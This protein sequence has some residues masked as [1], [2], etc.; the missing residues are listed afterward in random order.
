MARLDTN[1]GWKAVFGSNNEAVALYRIISLGIMLFIELA[2]RFQ[3][4]HAFYSDAG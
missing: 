4:L 3:Y 2:S 1:G